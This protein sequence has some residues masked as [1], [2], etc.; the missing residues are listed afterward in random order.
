MKTVICY[1]SG[2][3]NT[4]K[5]AEGFASI[6]TER[7]DEVLTVS[8]DG[9]T[10]CKK[11]PDNLIKQISDCDLFGLGYP[12]YAFNAPPIVLQF[13]KRLPRLTKNKRTFIFNSSGEP[14]KL[15][16]ISSLKLC[17]ILKRRRFDVTNEYHYCMPYNI[18]FRHSDEMACKMWE[19]ARRLIP[20]DAKNMLNGEKHLLKRVRCGA[21]IAWVMRCQQWGGQLNGRMYSVS[22]DCIRCGKCVNDCPSHNI[23]ITK[24]GKFKFGGKCLMCMRCAHLC[25][26]NAIRIGLFNG[27]KVN[28]PYSFIAPKTEE[29]KQH[30]NR[31]LTK[32]YEQ[33]FAEAE[34][35]IN[36]EAQ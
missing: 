31:L 29:E 22:K 21:L 32:A 34:Q 10:L 16:N 28:G 4:R 11:L 26:R 30:Y 15:N 13:A 19:T 23:R 17:G 35:R 2:T 7:G 3:G 24:K 9:L 8:V 25:P 33:Y 6:F 14:L 20:L 12:I 18:M 36:N 27:W 1:F 5:V